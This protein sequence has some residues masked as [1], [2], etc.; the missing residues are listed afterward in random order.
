MKALWDVSAGLWLGICQQLAQH[1]GAVLCLLDLPL[2]WSNIGCLG[3]P[4]SLSPNPSETEES[5]KRHNI[6]SARPFSK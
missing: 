4:G 3:L 1:M 2:H 5:L 6:L